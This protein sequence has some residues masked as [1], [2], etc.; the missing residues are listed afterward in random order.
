MEEQPLV[1]VICLCF[2]QV[3]FVSEAIKSVSMQTYRNIELIVV[4]DASTDSSIEIIKSTIEQLSIPVKTH[5][6]IEN[7]G[8][9]EAFN[10]GLKLSSGKYIVDLAAD[11]ILLKDRVKVGVSELEQLPNNFGVHYCEASHID[12]K[13]IPLT[14]PAAKKP[15]KFTGDIYQELIEYY[16]INPA[17]MMTRKFVLEALNGYDES[18]SYEDFDFWIRSSRSF[19]YAYSSKTL[20]QKRIVSNSL[21]MQQKIIRNHHEHSTFKVCQK[22]KDLNASVE[23]DDALKKRLDYEMSRCLRLAHFKLA[24]RYWQLK[25]SL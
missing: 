18:L 9:C 2:N 6:N 11:D 16:W 23:E 15:A 14:K 4:D 5:F 25:R 20:I 10:Q 21:S 3:R 24:Y 12:E 1:S 19:Q 7:A 17:T 8:N 13:G 22:I